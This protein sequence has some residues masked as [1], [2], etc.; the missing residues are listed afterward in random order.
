M[1][2]KDLTGRRFGR[3][4]VI[5]LA[6]V[7]RVR[8]KCLC[9]CGQTKVILADSL[10][11]GRS[12]SCGCFRKADAV[13]RATVHGMHESKEHIAWQNAKARCIPG[14]RTHKYYYGRG[15]TMCVEWLN[16]FQAFYDHIGPCPPGL[17]LDRIDNNR[18]YEP[19]NVRWADCT[20]QARNRRI[21]NKLTFQG[22]TLA[23]AAWAERT[24]V[25]A[26]N[27]RYR[28]KLGWSLDKIVA[29]YRAA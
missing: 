26:A 16:D 14:S 2:Y 4:T 15:I 8:W 27:I 5:E 6:A 18:G 7:N 10:S 25:N 24:G 22:E 11:T 1:K 9:D 19:G 12:I 21:T 13:R 23:I 3:L 17:T 28:Q 20:T 29:H